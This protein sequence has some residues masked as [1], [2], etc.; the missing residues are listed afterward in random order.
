VRASYSEVLL[1]C[2]PPGGIRETAGAYESHVRKRKEKKKK[3][4]EAENSAAVQGGEK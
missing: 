1:V 4:E 3:E 2:M